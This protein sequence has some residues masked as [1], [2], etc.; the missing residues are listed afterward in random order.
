M[1][2][3]NKECPRELTTREPEVLEH[4]LSVPD[5]RLEPLRTESRMATVSS[6]C[7]CGCATIDLVV[8]RDDAE[9]AES[10]S[11]AFGA[12]STAF[13]ARMLPPRNPRH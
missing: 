7:D 1:T 11:R 6:E 9:P 8:H 4:L 5:P 13:G 2:E 3:T 12:V 10:S